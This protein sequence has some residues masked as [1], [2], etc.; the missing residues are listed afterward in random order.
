MLI[1]AEGSTDFHCFF[2][3]KEYELHLRLGMGS[4]FDSIP[5]FP[6][7]PEAKEELC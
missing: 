6:H 3:D 1:E 2:I 4:K 5:M 7:D